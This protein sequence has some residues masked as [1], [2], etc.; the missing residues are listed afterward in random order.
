MR[1]YYW[2]NLV[3]SYLSLFFYK[4]FLNNLVV[5][6]AIHYCGLSFFACILD[7]SCRVHLF[8]ANEFVRCF[9]I[10][11]FRNLSVQCCKLCISIRLCSKVFDRETL[12]FYT[13]LHLLD[14]ITWFITVS[15]HQLI[16][17]SHWT[18]TLKVFCNYCLKNL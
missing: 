1:L 18:Y 16:T 15:E 7:P 9:V 13:L 14:Y 17:F 8:V 4:I 10:E 12:W 6:G 11:F 3:F 5:N 2:L